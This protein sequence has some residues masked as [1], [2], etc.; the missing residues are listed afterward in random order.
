MALPLNINQLLN[1]SVWWSGNAW[2]SLFAPQ[3]EPQNL[4]E[5][6]QHILAFISN[7]PNL[8]KKVIAKELGLSFITLRRELSAMSEIV[9]YTGASKGGHW[10][11]ID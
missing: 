10:E 1:G 4:T 3:N 8:S 5:R 6:Q 11:I 9:K 7:N 2:I